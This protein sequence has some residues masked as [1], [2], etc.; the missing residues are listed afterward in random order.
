MRSNRFISLF[1]LPAWAPYRNL[2]G[3][4]VLAGTGLL[5]FM[6][7][8]APAAPGG[9]TFGSAFVL[10]GVGAV[11]YFRGLYGSVPSG[12][13]PG[14]VWHRG[15]TA[16]G[17]AAWILGLC[18]TTFYVCLY[19][20]PAYLGLGNGQVPNWGLVALFD[21]L[22]QFLRHRPADQWF[23][24][25]SLYT[26]AVLLMGWK[27]MLK[28]RHDKYQQWRTLSV[29][30]FQ[31][32][33]AYLLPGFMLSMQQ[34][35]LYWTYF[36]P[37]AYSNATPATWQWQSAEG[38]TTLFFFF[39]LLM[40]LVGTPIL[41]W[42]FGKRWYCSWVCGCGGLAETAGDPFRHL[43]SKGLRAWKAERWMIHGVLV[44]VLVVTVV[45]WANVLWPG[46]VPTVWSE[47]LYKAYGFVIGSLFSGVI[48]VGFYPLLG[49]RV[50]CRFGCPMAAWMGLWQ[51]KAS[52]FRI[53]TNG[54]QC[55]SCG[56]CST[57][58]EM[59][60]DV[61][62]YAQRGQDV[63]R[64]ACVGCG[65][66][67]SVCPRGVLRLENGPIDISHRGAFLDSAAFPEVKGS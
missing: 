14:G 26:L 30:F 6:G 15:L 58:C 49:S 51:R 67:S 63:V 2:G 16:R 34:P 53:T 40:A 21:P 46:L 32:V 45:L 47:G 42:Y 31:L 52:R 22:S 7:L 55:I 60:I 48:G 4:M 37:L 27:F 10:L 24:Y 35:E 29:V 62:Y 41:T 20:W 17:M 64:A 36:W 18:L 19:W 38:L 61:R 57:Y 3:L 23:V 13:M 1:N 39:G 65:I 11:L 25:G 50:W 33:F 9:Q 56:N 5:I 44:G 8:S 54:G 28:Y 43:S 12:G 66:C 59:G